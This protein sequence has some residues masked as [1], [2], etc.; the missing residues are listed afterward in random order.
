MGDPGGAVLAGLAP[1]RVNRRPGFAAGGRA[2]GEPPYG[3]AERAPVWLESILRLLLHALW[4]GAAAAGG[5]QIAP[6]VVGGA[7][8]EVQEPPQ[9]ARML[10]RL[11]AVLAEA[12][13]ERGGRGAS[14]DL[15]RLAGWEPMAAMA[16]MLVCL[17]YAV[18]KLAGSL[19]AANT[20]GG[21]ARALMDLSLALDHGG[22]EA[23]EQLAEAAGVAPR[24]V[25]D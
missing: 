19:Y 11:E 24:A 6:H 3:A 8:H 16:A 15:W 9:V 1:F 14:E 17:I 2:P 20:V 18:C 22:A 23:A 10:Q 21:R 4:A 7:A 25:Y 13:R 5:A 12:E